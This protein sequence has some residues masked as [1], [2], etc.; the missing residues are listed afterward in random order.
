MAAYYDGPMTSAAGAVLEEVGSYPFFET[1]PSVYKGR[2]ESGRKDAV[3]VYRPRRGPAT[4]T[5]GVP[6]LPGP[7]WGS[8][9][10]SALS[11]TCSFRIPARPACDSF[12]ESGRRWGSL[13][14]LSPWGDHHRDSDLCHRET[15]VRTEASWSRCSNFGCL[16][17]MTS[18]FD[19]TACLVN[20][21]AG[22]QSNAF[23]TPPVCTHGG[24]W[25]P[26]WWEP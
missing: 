21:F 8:G 4:W 19:P 18:T 13:P 22:N 23:P 24:P 11:V 10:R 5:S 14:A 26:G 20:D 2:A 12:Q 15:D 16:N 17:K 7:G 9:S 25:G 6:L 3:I 1:D